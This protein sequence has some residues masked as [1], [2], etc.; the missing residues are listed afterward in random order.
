MATPKR[1]LK[2]H[3]ADIGDCCKLS[4]VLEKV[5]GLIEKYGEDATL[6]IQVEEDY[7]GPVIGTYIDVCRMETQEEAD[8][9]EK[10]EFEKK[11]RE[12]EA[13][14]KVVAKYRSQ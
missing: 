5:K 11:R 3:A 1:I 2:S 8:A 7:G 13:A 10:R 14:L 9:R 12:L 4:V 6:D